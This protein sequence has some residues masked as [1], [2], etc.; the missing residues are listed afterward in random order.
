MFL[1]MRTSKK[2]RQKWRH[3]YAYY[4]VNRLSLPF[5]IIRFLPQVL[6]SQ[7][8]FPLPQGYDVIYEQP[9][10]MMFA[11]MSCYIHLLC[12]FFANSNRKETI[13]HI[14]KRAA[15]KT[16]MWLCIFIRDKILTESWF[17]KLWKH[18]K[19]YKWKYFL[20]LLLYFKKWPKISA[21]F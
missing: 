3:A 8:P 20:I 10:K 9:L 13:Y 4:D 11:K 21:W 1:E 5:F 19:H 14:W 12:C 18:F 15:L 7:R 17:E 6:S 2:L 16:V